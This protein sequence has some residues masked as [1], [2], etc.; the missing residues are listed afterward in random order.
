[1]S[2]LDVTRVVEVFDAHGKGFERLAP[3]LIDALVTAVVLDG[4]TE[5]ERLLEVLAALAHELVVGT[6]VDALFRQIHHGGENVRRAVEQRACEHRPV[7]ALSGRVLFRI[8]CASCQIQALAGRVDAVL[9]VMEEASGEAVDEPLFRRQRLR[10][11]RIVANPI[12][13]EVDAGFGADFLACAVFYL[14]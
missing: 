9:G 10:G 1:M 11:R 12:A 3:Q 6:D 4:L 13:I 14:F 8:E 2:D 7:D 5:R